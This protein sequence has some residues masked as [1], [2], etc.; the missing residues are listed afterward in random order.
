MGRK[1]LAEQVVEETKKKAKSTFRQTISVSKKAAEFLFW[2]KEDQGAKIS[3]FTRLSWE[4]T[5][6][7]ED[8]LNLSEEERRDI[9][10][11]FEEKLKQN[12][13]SK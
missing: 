5:P 10:K 6:D 7:Y 4:N 9:R 1:R 8:F 11:R 3:E 12:G 13:K 2:I